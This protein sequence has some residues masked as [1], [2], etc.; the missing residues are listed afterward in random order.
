MSL[1]NYSSPC[2]VDEPEQSMPATCA[3]TAMGT[4]A[5]VK[6]F[7]VHDV[8]QNRQ[9]ADVVWAVQKKDAHLWLGDNHVLGTKGGYFRLVADQP[10]RAD[11]NSLEGHECTNIKAGGFIRTGCQFTLQGGEFCQQRQG[12][13]QRVISTHGDAGVLYIDQFCAFAK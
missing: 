5:G 7:R 6:V 10:L 4:M 2:Q 13:S 12:R 8:W 1:L 3:C 11:C 9:A